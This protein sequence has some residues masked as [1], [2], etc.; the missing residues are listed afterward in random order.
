[1]KTELAIIAPTYNEVDNIKLLLA[2]IDSSLTDVGWELIIVDDDSPDGTAK[3]ARQLASEDERVRCV[4]RIN[5]RGLASACVEGF[6]SSAAPY[7][8]VVDADAQ[9]DISKLGEML[10][11]LDTEEVDI[12]IGSRYM[13][14]GSTGALAKRRVRISRLATRLAQSL[15]GHSITDPMSGFFVMRRAYFSKVVHRL[16]GRGFKIL[17]D[18]LV[19][20][21]GIA[22]FKEIPY[23]M[24]ARQF[25]DSKLDTV[26]IWEFFT[27]LLAKFLGRWLPIRFLSFVSIGLSGVFVQLLVVFVLYRRMGMDYPEALIWSIVLAMTSNYILNNLFTFRDR[28]LRGGAF[29]RG[30][31]SFYLACSIGAMV[32]FAVANMLL[33]HGAWLAAATAIEGGASPV[34]GWGLATLLG[35]VAGAV[36]NYATTSTFT[37]R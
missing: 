6:L 32:N 8:A 31:F 1:M 34:P 19:S 13:D 10:R 12:V 25:G 24:R 28:M 21:H 37:W 14:E 5:R 17:L 35:A 18:L 9:H 30:L 20:P 26:V 23:T 36:W 33:S 4:Q 11:T 2:L 22:R 3:L 16:H 27:L 15:V 29:V 7:L